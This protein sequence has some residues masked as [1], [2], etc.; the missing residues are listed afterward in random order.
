MKIKIDIE[1][2][3]T[4]QVDNSRINEVISLLSSLEAIAL[5]QQPIKE[6]SGEGFTGRVLINE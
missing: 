2:Y 1:G 6:V 5:Q 3:G 4:Y